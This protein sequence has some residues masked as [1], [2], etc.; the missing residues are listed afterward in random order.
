MSVSSTEAGSYPADIVIRYIF[1][2]NPHLAPG[3]DIPGGSSVTME[4]PEEFHE[5]HNAGFLLTD[6]Y[7]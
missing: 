5:A 3:R 7:I 6:N 2:N 4:D 1:Q